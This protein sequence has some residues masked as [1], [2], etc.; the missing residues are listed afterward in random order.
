MLPEAHDPFYDKLGL[1]C[2]SLIQRRFVRGG[3]PERWDPPKL[4]DGEPMRDT[5]RLMASVDYIV[6]ASPG[7]GVQISV[8]TNLIYAAMMHFGGV[9]EPVEAGALFIPLTPLARRIGAE[10]DKR[11]R[12]R[13]VYGED[14]VLVK[15]VEIDPR[16]FLFL[17]DDDVDAIKAFIVREL[18]TGG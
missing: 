16:P 10:R 12:G 1:F 6:R 15:R 3:A 8:G 13:L 11:K 7:G 2:V 9:I 4:R 17:S 14:F 5:N 18:N